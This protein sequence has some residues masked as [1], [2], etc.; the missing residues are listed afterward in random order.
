MDGLIEKPE[1]FPCSKCAVKVD[2]LVKLKIH[3]IS[4]HATNVSTQTIVKDLEDKLVQ[5]F[6]FEF[7]LDKCIQTIDESKATNECFYCEQDIVGEQHLLEHRV[8]CHGATES[9][10]LFS[11]PIR[12][13]AL[14]YKCIMWISA[15][16]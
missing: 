6:N 11:F 5:T 7:S 16:I 4:V 14:L 12:P 3:E 1:E 15:R 10:S 2:S 9:P 8:T 13:K